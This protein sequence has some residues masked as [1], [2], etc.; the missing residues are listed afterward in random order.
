MIL[1]G[2]LLDHCVV[3]RFLFH[4]DWLVNLLSQLSRGLH[5]GLRDDLLLLLDCLALL[6]GFLLV[7][8]LDLLNLLHDADCL[9]SGEAVL[10]S[11]R[12]YWAKFSLFL[13][14]LGVG[15]LSLGFLR[16]LLISCLRPGI[17]FAL[18]SFTVSG[19]TVALLALAVGLV[20][21]GGRRIALNSVLTS[22]IFGCDLAL[23]VPGASLAFRR[24]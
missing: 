3:L 7:R 12:L 23:L 10:L 5:L 9:Q 19:L 17:T 20:E 24:R 4:D 1:D 21:V 2:W 13:L 15:G 18:L 22:C 16:G 6:N 8:D 11:R 14:G